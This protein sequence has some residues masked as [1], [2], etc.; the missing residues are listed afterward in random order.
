MWFVP[1]EAKELILAEN[2][3]RGIMARISDPPQFSFLPFE[4][5]IKVML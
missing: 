5:R 3:F 2:P 4:K 1:G